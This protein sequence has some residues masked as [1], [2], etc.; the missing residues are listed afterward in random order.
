MAFLVIISEKAFGPGLDGVSL[1]EPTLRLVVSGFC[2]KRG[3]NPKI[4]RLE[5]R[6]LF[7]ILYF[8][9]YYK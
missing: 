4:N 7:F 3:K 5:K 6:R 8:N 1:L 9:S 2:A